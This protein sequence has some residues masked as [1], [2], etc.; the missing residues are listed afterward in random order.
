SLS[1]H[2]GMGAVGGRDLPDDACAAHRPRHPAQRQRRRGN[3]PRFVAD[4]ALHSGRGCDRDLVLSR[5]V[6]LARDRFRI[7]GAM[8]ILV[9]SYTIYH[10]PNAYL[11]T[12]LLRRA[13]AE[14]SAVELL[15]RPIH[16]PRERG[17]MIAELLGGKENRNAGSYNH[18]DCHRWA[19]RHE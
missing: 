15:R 4:R 13:L 6:G 19:E 12:V 7:G 2:A 1:W 5:D 17:L 16:I 9:Y 8:T 14:L 11:G 10:S 3:P 18:E